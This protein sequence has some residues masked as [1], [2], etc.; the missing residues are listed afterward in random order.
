MLEGF[1]PYPLMVDLRS[2][3]E[4]IPRRGRRPG[5]TAHSRVLAVRACDGAVGQG[6]ARD[7]AAEQKR[8]IASA[9]L[10]PDAMLLNNKGAAARSRGPR[11]PRRRLRV[12]AA[13]SKSLGEWRRAAA[14]AAR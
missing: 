11:R 1:L 12:C 3:G 9:A 10:A 6:K 13:R 8:S 7:A 14:S 5:S 2:R 4:T